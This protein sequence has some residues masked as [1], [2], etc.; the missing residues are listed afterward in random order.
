MSAWAP[1]STR[2]FASTFATCLLAACGSG[3]I[4]RA[5]SETDAGD[6]LLRDAGESDASESQLDAGD[7]AREDAGENEPA[8]VVP[9]ASILHP[10]SM[11]VPVDDTATATEKVDLLFVIDNSGSMSQEQAK[12]AEQL[13]KLLRGLI[14]GVRDDGTMYNPVTDLHVGVVTTDLGTNGSKIKLPPSCE[15]FGDD[16]KLVKSNLGCT[17]SAPLGYLG[18]VPSS[19][20]DQAALD[21]A[22][23]DFTCLANV[24][25]AGCGFEQQLEAMYKAVAPN[26]VTFAAGTGGHGDGLNQGFLRDDAVLAVIH[27]SDEEDCSMTDKGAVLFDDNTNSPNVK[28]PGSDKNLGLNIRCAYRSIPQARI[29]QAEDAGLVHDV[30]RYVTD[31]KLNIKPNAPERIVFAAIVGIPEETQ[32]KPFQVMLDHPLMDF[33]VDPHTGAGD[34]TNR[35]TAARDVCRRCIVANETDCYAKPPNLPEGKPDPDLV[36]GAKPAIRFVK[37]AQ[38]FGENGLVRSI[39]AESYAPAI[40][41]ISDK[42]A[43]GLGGAC[44]PHAFPPDRNG[45]VAC[46]LLEIMPKGVSGPDACDA[47][48]GRVFKGFRTT[49]NDTRVICQVNQIAVTPSHE[50]V[51]NPKALPGVDPMVGWF[52]D[53]FTEDVVG[54]CTVNRRRRVSFH[55]A[56]AEP[57]GSTL[58]L[59]CTEVLLGDGGAPIC[60]DPDGDGPDDGAGDA[61][62]GGGGIL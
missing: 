21:Q 58:R 51:A 14:S 13:P 39:C 55:P 54:K 16:G 32:D 2:S 3:E 29:S 34:P 23:S 24:G 56:A 40:S 17:A 38:G 31:F 12:L 7:A 45:V 62:Q 36:T 50:L 59:D 22:I 26:S 46:N 1:M 37:T 49:G 28:L 20:I 33:A 11:W 48:R 43:Q 10:I 8:C 35:N 53:T 30:D 57:V 19:F 60:T 9:D 15:G 52:Y 42:I 4:D 44:L 47:S 18:Y 6:G 5:V 27:V 61:G 41:A 25:T